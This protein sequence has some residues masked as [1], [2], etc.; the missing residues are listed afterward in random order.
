MRGLG[1]CFVPSES[2]VDPFSFKVMGASHYLG[3]LVLGFR[4]WG[5]QFGVQGAMHIH[6]SG[7]AE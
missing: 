5:S 3:A 7:F 1:I 6:G 4:A 2:L